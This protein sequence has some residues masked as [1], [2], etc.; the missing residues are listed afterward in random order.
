MSRYELTTAQYRRVVA[1]LMYWQRG[2]NEAMD[3]CG[4]PRSEREDVIGA[5]ASAGYTYNEDS[6]TLVY[7]C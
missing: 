2:L 7:S 3:D 4:L 1:H 5:L 6:D